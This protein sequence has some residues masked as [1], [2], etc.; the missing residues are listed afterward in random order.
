MRRTLRPATCLAALV[1]SLILGS[2]ASSQAASAR[3]VATACS[4]ADPEHAD[5]K[6]ELWTSGTVLRGANVYQQDERR[7]GN[8][9][10]F[11]PVYVMGDFKALRAA[12]ANYVNFS[13]PGIFHVRG[14]PAWP[15]MVAHLDNLV[16]WAKAAGLFIV[17]SVRTGPGR[18]E[19]DITDDPV[20]DRTVFTSARQQAAWV[21]MWKQIATRY[22]ADEHIVGFDLMVEPHDVPRATWRKFA[23]QMVDGIRCVDPVTPILVSPAGDWGTASD[24]DGWTPLAGE[25]IVYAV[26]QYEPRSFTHDTAQTYSPEDLEA[27]FRLM[28]DWLSKYPGQRLT[29]NEFGANKDK[30]LA[31]RF[32]AD[33]LAR[34]ERL[35]VN[36][37][38]WL[39]EVGNTSDPSYAAEFDFK[40][41]PAVMR[42]FADNWGLNTVFPPP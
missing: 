20:K 9:R 3:E 29:V 19:G 13:V 2:C 16:S 35:G 10:P 42:V 5:R 17:I 25:R 22:G 8:G 36:H 26:H 14:S 40:R 18:G 31:G 37:A 33:E 32:L 4:P 28:G 27:A 23:Q 34:L 39:W 15:E 30:T 11:G 38:A 24:L 12:R 7:S 1:L 21:E 6:W 41:S